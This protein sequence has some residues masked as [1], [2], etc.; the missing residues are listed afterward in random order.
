MNRYAPTPQR[1]FL[2]IALFF[3]GLLVFVYP[4]VQA[5]DENV[6]FYRAYQIAEGKWI[7][8]RRGDLVGGDMPVS[9]FK[10][11]QPFE[12]LYTRADRK[13]SFEEI[14]SFLKLPL[15]PEEKL[16]IAFRNTAIF[17][18]VPYLPQAAGIW[19]GK[20][21]HLPPL[22]LLYLGR[23]SALGAWIFLMYGAIRATPVFK[24]PL[25]ALALTP[26]SLSE[27]ASLAADGFTNG[28]SFLFIAVCLAFGLGPGKK[29]DLRHGILLLALAALVT[30]SKQIYILLLGLLL[31][32]PESSFGSKKRR[33]TFLAVALGGCLVLGGLWGSVVKRLYFPFFEGISPEQQFAYLL[34]HPFRFP[35]VV[36]NTLRDSG[37]PFMEE[38]VGKFGWLDTS[39]PIPVWAGYWAVLVALALFGGDP[40]KGMASRTRLIIGGTFLA[41]FLAVCFALYLHW[42]FVGAEG[43][44]GIQGRYFI[45]F[46][47]LLFLVV[48]NRRLAGALP[49]AGP[50]VLATVAASTALA[51]AAA[52]MLDRYYP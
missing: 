40:E 3:G 38:F 15:N 13:T 48:Y 22:A 10:T 34:Q 51:S 5:P 32:I 25:L 7:S 33:L 35:V 28:V 39:L 4:P 26:M 47:P 31:L 36:W 17:S 6:H 9:L 24:W 41:G 27:A 21:H 52:A 29:L 1:V 14:Y 50:A 23:L 42:S 20:A 8:D 16:P 43:I 18:P 12:R 11:I 2:C 45:P 37:L 46:S 49:A 19:L 44:G 30:L